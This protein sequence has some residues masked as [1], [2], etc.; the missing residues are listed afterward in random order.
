[1]F[2]LTTLPKNNGC[3]TLALTGSV[4]EEV[5]PEIYRLI[6]CRKQIDGRVALDLSE[7]TLM[8]RMSARFFAEQ[9][10]RGIELVDCP[11]YLKPWILREVRNDE[12]DQ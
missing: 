10:Q 12:T 2:S 4:S 3:V 5:L 7:V 9:L 1:M 11:S 8:D 6:D